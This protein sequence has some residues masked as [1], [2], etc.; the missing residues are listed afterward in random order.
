MTH[1]L[2]VGDVVLDQF[3][4]GD[5]TRISPE[6]STPVLLARRTTRMLGGAGNVACGVAALGAR[7][8]LFGVIG[9]DEEGLV[10]ERGLHRAGVTPRLIV[11]PSR[12]TTSKTRYVSIQHSS[13][14]LRVDN[15][16]TIPIN[17]L[18]LD[19]IAQKLLV[20][21][22]PDVKCVVLSDYNKGVLRP[23]VIGAA[24]NIAYHLGI[25]SI[26]D[27]KQSDWRAYSGATIL[28]PNLEELGLPFDA[29]NEVIEQKAQEARK[30]FMLRNV[31]VTCGDRGMILV[32]ERVF[33]I[34]AHPV[35]VRDVSGAGDT[36]VAAL[37]VAL[38]E[39]ADIEKAVNWANDAAAISVGKNGT[40]IVTRAEMMAKG[41][42]VPADDWTLL[43]QRISEWRTDGQSIGFTNGC[44]DLLHPGHVK[45]LQEARAACDKL[46]V[47]LNSDAS[48]KAL[49]GDSRPV[50]TEAARAAV[51]S[52]MDA[53]DLVVIFPDLTPRRLIERVLPDVLVKGAD[54]RDA[55]AVGESVAKRTIYVDLLPGHS[56]SRLIKRDP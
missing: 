42:M 18:I 1:L 45:L 7:C 11:D 46:V 55:G 14:L 54:Y 32:G 51:L 23:Q 17:D 36:A 30:T 19:R 31:L 34:P 35:K 52:A 48:V 4:Y 33:H 8:T 26:I 44:F 29:P 3:I 49:K 21:E 10:V 27:P 22:L 6:A 15:E 2:I 37:A 39:G 40:A 38:A 43:N 28:K 41:K 53:V 20:S 56:T 50:Q 24:M 16:T 47:G 12:Q 5:V 25:P 13:H 9:N